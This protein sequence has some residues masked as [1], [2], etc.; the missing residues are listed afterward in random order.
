MSVLFFYTLFAWHPLDGRREA[1]IKVLDAAAETRLYGT[2]PLFLFDPLDAANG[3]VKGLHDPIEA[4]W[5]ALPR[6]VRDLFVRAFGEG[7]HDPAA[8]VLETEWRALRLVEDASFA[9][10]ACGFE[11]VADPRRDP[12]VETACRNCG[13]GLDPPA[14][15]VV[16]DGAAALTVGAE[17]GGDL[18]ER[19]GS[20]A[21]AARVE[22][23]P[24]HPERIG[25]RNLTDKPWQVSLPDQSV[26]A[27]PP[28]QVV[29]IVSGAVLGFGRHSGRIVGGETTL[30]E[31]V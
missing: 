15:L 30:K 5:N 14:M 28:G 3:P 26:Y 24:K 18:F 21:P 4:R 19:G 1:E 31:A 16:G 2:E 29:R 12:V 11:H 8:R 23:H 25:L 9:C 7:L 27:V 10:E 13:E 6:S 20:P 22:A 17:L